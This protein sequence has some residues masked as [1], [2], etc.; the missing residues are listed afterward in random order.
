M[1]DKLCCDT[2]LWWESDDE[3]NRE[4]LQHNLTTAL[5]FLLHIDNYGN[6]KIGSNVCRGQK[7]NYIVQRRAAL[8]PESSRSQNRVYYYEWGQYLKARCQLTPAPPKDQVSIRSESSL[9]KC[10]LVESH[11]WAIMIFRAGAIISSFT[12]HTFITVQ[13]EPTKQLQRI[14]ILWIRG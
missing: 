13:R 6:F 12:S 5:G 4:K 3:K 14:I 7:L 1:C 9:L 10:I 11:S 8:C 2:K